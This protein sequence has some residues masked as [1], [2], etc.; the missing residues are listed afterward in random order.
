[1]RVF[2]YFL[3]ICFREVCVDKNCGM[4]S[5]CS[6]TNHAAQVGILAFEALGKESRKISDDVL[7]QMNAYVLLWRSHFLLLH[8]K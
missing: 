1:M 3:H 4:A 7:L 8:I 2:V 5:L 6:E